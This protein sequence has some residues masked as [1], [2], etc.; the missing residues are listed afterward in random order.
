MSVLDLSKD[1]GASLLLVIELSSSRSSSDTTGNA[2]NLG[3][4]SEASF[5]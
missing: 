2:E 5:I 4:K 3:D 1:G